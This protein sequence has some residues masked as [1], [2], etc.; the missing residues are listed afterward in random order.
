MHLRLSSSSG[1][2][3]TS[4]VFFELAEDVGYIV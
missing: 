1:R 3:T 4:W 2:S